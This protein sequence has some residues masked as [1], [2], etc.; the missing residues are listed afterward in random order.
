MK[1]KWFIH[2][3]K[4]EEEIIEDSLR[5]LHEVEGAPKEAVEKVLEFLF[6]IGYL[7]EED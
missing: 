3:R 4:G 5:D 2:R 6:N 7:K 1:K